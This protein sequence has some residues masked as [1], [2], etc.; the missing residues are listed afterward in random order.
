MAS[1]NVSGSACVVAKDSRIT[2]ALFVSRGVSG[3]MKMIMKSEEIE[4][5]RENESEAR[6]CRE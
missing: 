4:R 6:E 5:I 2:A 3:D 1:S